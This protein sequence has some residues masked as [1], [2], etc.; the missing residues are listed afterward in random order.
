MF[1]AAEILESRCWSRSNRLENVVFGIDDSR[2]VSVCENVC[3][4]LSPDEIGIATGNFP[5]LDEAR[6][7]PALIHAVQLGKL[8]PSDLPF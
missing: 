4:A 7:K 3:T 1:P 6:R 2:R 8:S 5:E